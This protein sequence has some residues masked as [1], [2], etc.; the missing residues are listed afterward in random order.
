MGGRGERKIEIENRKG[1][2]KMGGDD[3]ETS[4]QVMFAS[5][6]LFAENLISSLS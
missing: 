3:S 4:L 5:F 6:F 2:E 1:K